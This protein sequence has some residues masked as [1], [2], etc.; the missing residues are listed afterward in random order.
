MASTT[1]PLILDFDQSVMPLPG[2]TTRDLANW[3]EEIR[4]GCSMK[5]MRRLAFAIAPLLQKMPR[6]VFMGSGDYHHITWLLLEQYRDFGQP[7]QVVV[8]D[9]HPDNMRYPWGIHCGSWVYHASRL[10]FVEQVNVLGITSTDVEKFRSWEN[11]LS[12]LRSGKIRY[13]C[14]GRDI[15]WMGALGI[16]QSHSFDSCA[17]MLEAFETHLKANQTPVY[18]SIDKD[19]LSPQDAHTNWD[20]GVMRLNEMWSVMDLLKGRVVGSDVTGEVSV[21]QYRSRFKQFL[22]DLDSQPEITAA[23]SLRWQT[24]HHVINSKIIEQLG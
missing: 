23:D 19:V 14:I 5:S 17:H 3:Q 18:L 1:N 13:W 7:I 20:Q 24:E 6:V 10:P 9:N 2:S 12:G 8:L 22:S 15:G 21:Y 11:H 4:F 16:R